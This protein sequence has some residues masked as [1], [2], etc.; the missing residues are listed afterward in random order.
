ML[1]ERT[2]LVDQWEPLTAAWGQAFATHDAV[3]V[4]RDDFFARDADA[5][6]SPANSFGIMDGGLDRAIRDTIGG[7]IQARVQDVIL[8]RHHGELPVG[9][10]EVV[11]TGHARWPFLIVAPTM[12]VPESVANTLNAYLAFRAVLLAVRHVNSAGQRIRTIVVP[13]LGT[14]VGAMDA[15]RC[16]AQ[17]RIA[18][19]Q[20]AGPA[21]IP[22]FDTIH[23]IH[24]KLRSSL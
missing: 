7:A 22:S 19:D 1:P 12:R 24:Q 13:G 10:A 3:E 9:A 21:R 6:V 16:A 14:G 23:K 11:E 17:M 18:Y 8:R 4:A 15:R 2:Y 5:L 20:V